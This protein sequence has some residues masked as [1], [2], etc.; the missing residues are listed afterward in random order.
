MKTNILTLLVFISSVLLSIACTSDIPTNDK[1]SLQK[2]DN[3]QLTNFVESTLTR[4]TGEY[5]GSGLNFYWTEGDHLWVN[6]TTATPSVLM[7]DAQNNIIDM[8]ENNPAIPTAVR[9]A[10]AASFYFEGAF[11][12]SSYPVRYTGKGNADGNKVTIKAQQTQ[13]I[14]NDASHI[15]EDGDCAV[16]T[17][18]R[19]IGSKQYLFTLNHKAAYATFLPYNASGTIDGAKITKIKVT[20]NK[21]IAGTFNF[22]DNG[23]S[24]A[25]PSNPSNSIELVL[26]DFSIP[27]TATAITNAATMV[28]APGTYTNFTV[29]YTLHDTGS[30]VTGTISKTYPTVTFTAGLNK[31]VSQDLLIKVHAAGSYYMWDAEQNYWAGYE[32]GSANP[33]QPIINGQSNNN[34]PTNATSSRMYKFVAYGVPASHSC[35]NCPNTNEAIWYA[36]AGDPHWDNTKLWA[37]FGHLHAGG[38][39]FKKKAHISGFKSDAAPNEFGGYDYRTRVNNPACFN[40]NVTQGKPSNTENYFFLPPLGGFLTGYINGVFHNDL[41]KL[42]DFGSNGYYWTSSVANYW[43]DSYSLCFSSTRVVINDE[44]ATKMECGNCLWTAE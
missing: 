4:T 10:T 26:S 1:Q 19:P 12:A 32:W 25:T 18:T 21:P 13:T 17:A 38:M 14:P 11:T 8:L 6:N 23:L 7:Q 43:A 27:Q 9:R 37:M 29:E 30:N 34:Y 36:Y 35:M 44:Y 42:Y 3:R 40:T 41:G 22:N 39:W 28:I 2:R 5:D 15:G 24:T 20:A 16:A 33:Q 31:R